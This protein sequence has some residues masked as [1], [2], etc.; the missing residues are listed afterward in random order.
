MGA[1]PN[2]VSQSGTVDFGGMDGC[3][4]RGAAMARFAIRRLA[5]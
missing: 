1:V 4:G 5:C 2:P 3:I